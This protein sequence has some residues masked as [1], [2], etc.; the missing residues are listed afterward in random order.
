MKIEEWF[1]VWLSVYIKGQVKQNT[2]EKY[3][4]VMKSYVIS[5]WKDREIENIT[6]EDIVELLYVEL[7]QKRGLSVSGVNFV[8]GILKRVFDVAKDN[9]II[10]VNPCR[11]IKRLP[12]IGQQKAEAFT[13]SEQLKV[14]RHIEK[15]NNPK[16]YG[17]IICLYTGLRIGELLALKWSDIDLKN[18]IMY[19]NKSVDQKGNVN[20]PKTSAG[21]RIIPIPH[22]LITT[23]RR[24][25][26]DNNCEYVIS[27]EGRQTGVRSY[28][29]LFERMLRKIGIRVLK[30][31]TLR[32]TFATRAIESGM[33]VKTLSELMGH[34]N[35]SITLNCYTHCL[36]EHKRQAMNRLFRQ[37]K[38]N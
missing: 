6:R 20:Q 16:L 4:R 22:E 32:H 28:Q 35:V 27:T 14:E 12:N 7:R 36:L 18:R 33:D 29:R 23:F 31:H 11:N 19:V 1:D 3:D 13:K 2:Y 5:Y 8:I 34:S 15:A 9:G 25:K 21:N 38:G 30:F 17:I 24:L 26:A 10:T 37:K